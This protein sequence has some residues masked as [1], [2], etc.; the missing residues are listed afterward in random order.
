MTWLRRSVAVVRGL[1][2]RNAVADEI[3]EEMQFHI[4][5]RIDE[6][7]RQGLAA[8]EAKRTAQRQFGN[9]AVLQDEGYDIRGAGVWD[10]IWQD[11]RHAA[12]RLRATPGFTITTVLTLALG[13]G[14]NASFFSLMNG[15]L[16]RGVPGASLDRV[17]TLFGT[18]RGVPDPI[19][20]LTNDQRES[21]AAQHLAAIESFFTSDPLLAAVFADNGSGFLSCEMVSGTYFSSLGLVPREGRLLDPADDRDIGDGTPVVISERLRR[22]WF[23]REVAVGKVLRIAGTTLAIVG[24]APRE[25]RGTFLPTIMSV[26]T[27]TTSFW[28]ERSVTVTWV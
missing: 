19:S 4:D 22:S 9:P 26:G 14:A 17:A 7:R 13:I 27:N 21:L 1:L 24:V 15:V 8:T 20:G 10:S 6:Y 12:R 16:L 3:R 25:F 2:R 23:G 18:S 11:A 28:I 5:A